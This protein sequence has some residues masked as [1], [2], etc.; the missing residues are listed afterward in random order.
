MPASLVRSGRVVV[1]MLVAVRVLVE[2][3]VVG[4]AV[5]ETAVVGKAVVETDLVSGAVL[6]SLGQTVA[7]S[8]LQ[9]PRRSARG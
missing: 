3:A 8:V 2:T 5:V 4:T 7:R 6:R 9:S 1:G